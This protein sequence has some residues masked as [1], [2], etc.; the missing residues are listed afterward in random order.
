M[1]QLLDYSSLEAW[2]R[3]IKD[4]AAFQATNLAGSFAA[5]GQNI[6]DEPTMFT[7]LSQRHCPAGLKALGFCLYFHRHL[8]VRFSQYQAMFFRVIN[9]LAH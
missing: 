2:R 1:H 9:R 6:I 3:V 8:H 7:G 4:R 5:S